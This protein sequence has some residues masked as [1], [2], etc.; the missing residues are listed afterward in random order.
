MNITD[1]QP[2]TGN[3]DLTFTITDKS[4]PREFEKF[5]NKG[6]VCNATA[7]DDTGTVSLTLWNDDI[8][9][10]NVGDKVHLTNGYVGEY[11]GS[12][13]LSTGKFGK[14]EVIGKAE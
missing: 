4:T 10:V 13:Q 2:R 8:D 9:K 6:R 14:L 7:Q 1:L 12:L 11:Q 5:G 3:I